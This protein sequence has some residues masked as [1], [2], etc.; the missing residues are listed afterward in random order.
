MEMTQTNHRRRHFRH[1]VINIWPI[2]FFSTAYSS[3]YS[4]TGL[5]VRD[6]I[7]VSPIVFCG[8]TYETIYFLGE[9]AAFGRPHGTGCENDKQTKLTMKPN[10]KTKGLRHKGIHEIINK[11]E[12][13]KSCKISVFFTYVTWRFFVTRARRGNMCVNKPLNDNPRG[14]SKLMRQS[15]RP[16]HGVF[17]FWREAVMKNLPSSL[18]KNALK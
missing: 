11:L 14:H 17:T 10:P 4:E 18:R 13:L 9:L 6:Q 12:V 3:R 5:P 8:H 15:G 16:F 2:R 7:Y 1:M